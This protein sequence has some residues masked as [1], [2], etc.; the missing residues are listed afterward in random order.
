[1]KRDFEEWLNTFTDSI[2]SYD[3]YVDFKKPKIRVIAL[4]VMDIPYIENQDLTLQY[5]GHWTFGS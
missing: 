2:A 4:N 1:M 5:Y 3:Y